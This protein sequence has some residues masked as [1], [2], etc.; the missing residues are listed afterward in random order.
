MTM[1]EFVFNGLITTPTLT[2]LGLSESNVFAAQV[3]DGTTTDPHPE[4]DF[5]VVYRISG[6]TPALAGSRGGGRVREATVTLWAYD[7][8]K[9]FDLRIAPILKAWEELMDSYEAEDT[10]DGYL[11]AGSYIGQSDDGWD[12]VY[13]RIARS[14]AYTIVYTGS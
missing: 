13:E 12:D 6:T 10:G 4:L 11:I 5:F 2:S 9:D 1:R 7:K 14:S 3:F 8:Q